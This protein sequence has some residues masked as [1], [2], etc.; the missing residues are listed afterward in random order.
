MSVIDNIA[1]IDFVKASDCELNIDLN[2]FSTIPHTYSLTESD[3]RNKLSEMAVSQIEV[4]TDFYNE[5]KTL[6]PR[7]PKL[8]CD[9]E[10]KQLDEV[11][12]PEFSPTER[13]FLEKV[14]FLEVDIR[15][16]E[17]QHLLRVLAE[18]SDVFFNFTND[19]GKVTQ[20]FHVKLK[21]DSE[22]RKKNLSKILCIT[23]TDLEVY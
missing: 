9:T 2:V 8:T 4:A 1:C 13:M 7:M 19:Y 11:S 15:Y 6:Q 17:L 10:R 5:V 18:N 16:S 21:E 22:L 3:S 14:D 12:F 23:T 20:E